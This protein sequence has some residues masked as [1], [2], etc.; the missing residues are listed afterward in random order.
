MEE[1]LDGLKQKFL[2][3]PTNDLLRLRILTIAPPS[4]SVRK[5]ANEF[6]TSFRQAK[7][8]KKLRN[9]QGVLASTTRKASKKLPEGTINK[10]V[11]FYNSDIHGRIMPGKKD[12]VSVKIDGRRTLVKKRLL[13][14]DLKILHQQFKEN[15][16]EHPIS[17]SAFAKLRPKHYVTAANAGTHSVCICTIHENCKLMLE[18]MDIEKLT[19]NSEHPLKNY[20]DCLSMMICETPTCACY[21]GTCP[22]CPSIEILSNFLKSRLK[23]TCIERILCSVWTSTDCSNLVTDK[24][25]VDD[26]IENLCDRLKLLK[27]HS[28]IAKQQSL[29]L[30]ATT[31]T[32]KPGEV[33]V[34]Y[35]LS[36]NYA[37]VIQDAA[38]AYHYNHDQ[39]T[40]IPVVYYYCVGNKI[41]HK[42]LIFISDCLS[43]DTVAVHVVQSML[44]EE[45]KKNV[46]LKRIIYYSDGAKQYFKNRFQI[47][48]LTNHET[49]FGVPADWHFHV[50][51]H[52][53]TACDGIGATF[54]RETT[55]ASVML[56]H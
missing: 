29:H 55:K 53:K 21:L 15:N 1:L 17:F 41:M 16:P 44:L 36:E 20:K 22:N 51:T 27:P 14:S 6:G 26:F 23:E 40:V 5:I 33:L 31:K 25:D 2:F 42:S 4:W 28:F 46:A 12:I 30:E 47:A 11:N 18:A 35:D 45:I 7:K 34:L 13:L 56:H 52:G 9:S 32:L 37:Y 3:L 8:A 38:Q 50:T 39:C 54:K 19:E 49:D 43:H 10:V 24:M 48:N